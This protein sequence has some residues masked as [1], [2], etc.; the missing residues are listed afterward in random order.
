MDRHGEG[1]RIRAIQNEAVML[2]KGDAAGVA[3]WQRIGRAIAEIERAAPKAG[4]P[5]H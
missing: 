2:A 4:E 5:V 1:A 3:V